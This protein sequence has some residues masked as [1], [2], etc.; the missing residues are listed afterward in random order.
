MAAI[1]TACTVLSVSNAS[2]IALSRIG[3]KWWNY[4]A[5]GPLRVNL[6]N[7]VHLLSWKMTNIQECKYHLY[8]YF[9][10]QIL[11]HNI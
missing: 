10:L 4:G 2:E 8:T 1:R 5:I 9:G 3:V 11:D 7:V 6:I